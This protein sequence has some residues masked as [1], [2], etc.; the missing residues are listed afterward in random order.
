MGD[1]PAENWY[2]REVRATRE[3]RGDDGVILATPDSHGVVVGTRPV[4]PG[5]L[6]FWSGPMLAGFTTADALVRWTQKPE[7][8]H[9]V[10]AAIIAELPPGAARDAATARREL[11]LARYGMPVGLR[12]LETARRDLAEELLDA[13]VYGVE[14]AALMLVEHGDVE[15]SDCATLDAAENLRGAVGEFHPQAIGRAVRKLA[16]G[17]R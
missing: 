16:R 14:A 3:I 17:L 10:W 6:V 7:G 5:L 2:L 13:T 12:D 9:D 8:D 11:G 15:K 1:M 4:E